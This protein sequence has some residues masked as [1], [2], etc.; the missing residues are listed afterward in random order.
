MNKT[1]KIGLWERIRRIPLLYNGL[2]IGAILLGMVLFAHVAM[3]VSTRHG[4]RRTVPVLTGIPLAEAE[5]LAE[6]NDLE[7]IVN[8][9]LYVTLYEGG[10]VLDQ[11]PEQG[12][13]VKPGRKIYVTINSFSQRMVPMPYVAGRSLR[14]AKN[15]LEI[16]GLEI[17]RL[18]YRADM[19]TNYVLEQHYQGQVVE[20]DDRI[21]AEAGSGVT[22]YVGV[23]D[24]Y[25]EAWVPQVVGQSLR[26]AQGR[27]W[28]NGFNVGK[29]TYDEGIDLLTQKDAR[30][31]RQNPELGRA[32]RLGSSVSLF[33]TLD[34][35]R[36]DKSRTEAE[37]LARS[38]TE[39]RLKQEE[40]ADSLA[41]VEMEQATREQPLESEADAYFREEMDEF[42]D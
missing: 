33:L 38:L 32:Q 36:I 27:L 5:R 18:V 35:E 24:G 14:Q 17:E 21:Q 25:G 40:R 41:R 11:L 15:M 22:L 13:E 30:V 20:A 2:W 4:A 12:V 3:R 29:I 34:Q 23:K 28:E 16:A 8:D 6:R 9:S 10:I 42:F 7:L 39:A 1:K 26:E 37:K 19:A 31:W